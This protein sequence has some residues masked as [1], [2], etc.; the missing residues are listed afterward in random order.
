MITEQTNP[1]AIKHQGITF[2]DHPSDRKGRTWLIKFPDMSKEY[3]FSTNEIRF[4]KRG[5]KNYRDIGTTNAIHLRF[6]RE[7]EWKRLWTSLYAKTKWGTKAIHYKKAKGGLK[8][9][10]GVGKYMRAS[11][12]TDDPIDFIV[13]NRYHFKVLKDDFDE[14][15]L[16]SFISLLSIQYHRAITLE[17]DDAGYRYFKLA[18]EWKNDP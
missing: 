14:D 8:Y 5:V 11:Y 9:L 13:L 3:I 7:H 10:K 6:F 16:Q 18:K 12:Y 15:M 17:I 4:L 2:I 1:Y